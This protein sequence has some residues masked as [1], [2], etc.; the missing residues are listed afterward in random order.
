MWRS[1]SSRAVRLLL[2]IL[3]AVAACDGGAPSPRIALCGRGDREAM[4]AAVTGFELRFLDAA[5]SPIGEPVELDA[6]DGHVDGDIPPDAAA[7]EVAGLDR[8]G[9]AIAAGAGSVSAADGGCA[10]VTLT[11]HA[12]AA[13]GGVRCELVA[14]TCRFRDESGAA[15]TSQTLSWG[16]GD[17]DDLRGVTTDTFLQE[18]EDSGHDAAILEAGPSPL[19]LALLRF[20]LAALPPTAVV[21]SARLLLHV[22]ADADCASSQTFEL[23]EVLEAWSEAATWSDRVP[24]S[25]WSEPGCGPDSCAAA[26]IGMLVAPETAGAQEAIDLDVAA[27]AGWVAD[28]ASNAGLAIAPTS[29]TGTAVHLDASETDA[30]PPSLEITYR[31]E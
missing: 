8:D 26:P 27:V 21:E 24:G 5:G 7:F 20:D 2:V 29:D 13:C 10:C 19:R 22:C 18:D 3:V 9:A 15:I 1:A 14:D 23:L 25:A 16:E 31:L 17:G 6:G 28:P 4:A 11:P 30:I 12:R